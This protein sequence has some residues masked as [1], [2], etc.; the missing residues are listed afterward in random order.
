[1]QL[2]KDFYAQIDSPKES[3][4]P[5]SQTTL[6]LLTEEEIQQLEQIWIELAVWKR[7]QSH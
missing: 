1:M 6:A 7:N 3:S 4:S 5:S 2:K